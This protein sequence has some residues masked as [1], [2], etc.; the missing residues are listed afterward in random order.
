MC[1]MGAHLDLSAK[2][3]LNKYLKSF[4]SLR[5][6]FGSQ[7]LRIGLICKKVPSCEFSL[8]LDFS[9]VCSNL[10]PC[11]FQNIGFLP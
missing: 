9:V 7:T 2:I 1:K 10:E 3:K 4:G 5:C 8:S 11:I 6:D